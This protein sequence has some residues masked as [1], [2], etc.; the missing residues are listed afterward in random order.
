VAYLGFFVGDG[1]IQLMRN[2][3]APWVRVDQARGFNLD[4]RWVMSDW[5][6]LDR[7]YEATGWVINKWHHEQ[8]GTVMRRDIF[9]EPQ[10]ARW[11]EW[12]WASMGLKYSRRDY[13]TH[14]QQHHPDALHPLANDKLNEYT[15]DYF[16]PS[17]LRAVAER[18][19]Q[20]RHNGDDARGEMLPPV[21]IFS[22][23]N[24]TSPGPQ[25]QWWSKY[26]TL[27]LDNKPSPL[28]N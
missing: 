17:D 6:F 8:G 26:T 7:I 27:F 19:N 9:S 23:R 11:S 2:N 3:A 12:F 1:N 20:V 22:Q 18:H 4:A 10:M 15:L 24:P 28:C 21:N 16:P 14:V 13:S 25:L 5:V